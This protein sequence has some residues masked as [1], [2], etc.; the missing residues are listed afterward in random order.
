MKTITGYTISF[1][2]KET[3]KSRSAIDAFFSRHGIKPLSTEAL[4]PVETLDLL[5]KS[6]VGRP[7]K[8]Q[9]VDAPKKLKKPPKKS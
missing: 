5:L 9:P 3:G 6:K 8:K 4:Y 2:M 7:S 1:L